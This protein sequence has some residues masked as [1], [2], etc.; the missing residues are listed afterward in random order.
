MRAGKHSNKISKLC[1]NCG[2]PEDDAHLFFHCSFSR[3]VWFSASKPLYTSHLPV[4]QDGIQNII[5]LIIKPQDSEDHI[6]YILTMLWYIWKAR[7]DKRFNNKNWTVW[8]IHNSVAADLALFKEALSSDKREEAALTNFAGVIQETGR[9]LQPATT[10]M[11]NTATDLDNHEVQLNLNWQNLS[12]CP[13]DAG[14]GGQLQ[15]D[16]APQS[17]QGRNLQQPN[18]SGIQSFCRNIVPPQIGGPRCYTDAAILPDSPNNPNRAAG[19]GIFVVIGTTNVYIR[20]KMHECN[21]VIMAEAAAMLLAATILSKLQVQGGTFL[22]DNQILAGYFNNTSSVQV[23]DWRIKH[24]TQS[25][26]NTT[27]GKDL[28]VLKIHRSFNTTAHTLAR[29]AFRSSSQN[30][31]FSCSCP[32]HVSQCPLCE[33]INVNLEFISLIAAACC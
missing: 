24:I 14:T 20:A 9:P 3:A 16:M 19:I 31:Q 27:A 30:L 23:P 6:L 22:T 29:Q 28:K 10:T 11:Q 17:I 26:I 13:L 5:T 15:N 2:E 12:A 33:A 21:S 25:F 32:S 18:Q 1:S 7:N 4:E 8:Q